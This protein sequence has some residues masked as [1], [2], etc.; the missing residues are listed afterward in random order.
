LIGRFAERPIRGM[1]AA[2]GV[3]WE[4]PPGKGGGDAMQMT[5]IVAYAKR[6]ADRAG[7]KA[8]AIAGQKIRDSEEA[9]DNAAVRDWQR[10]RACLLERRGPRA[11]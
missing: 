4:S 11:T 10:I 5:D 9:G 3:A 7:P 8:L 1:V 2:P 6:M